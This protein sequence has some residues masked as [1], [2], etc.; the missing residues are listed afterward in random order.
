MDWLDVWWSR[1]RRCSTARCWLNWC[2]HDWRWWL[3]CSLLLKKQTFHAGS[4]GLRM[5]SCP[6]CAPGATCCGTKPLHHGLRN[7]GSF[8]GNFRRP[9]LTWF[10]SAAYDLQWR[11]FLCCCLQVPWRTSER[12]QLVPRETL[13]LWPAPDRACALRA[14]GVRDKVLVG[15]LG[16]PEPNAGLP[17][18]FELGAHVA[19]RDACPNSLSEFC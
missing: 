5:R 9:M 17:L 18:R 10:N 2:S 14:T 11:F 8:L 15:R 13:R 4:T 6:A 3:R 1:F 7:V 16:L 19:T 12:R